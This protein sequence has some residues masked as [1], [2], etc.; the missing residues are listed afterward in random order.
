MH[1]VHSYPHLNII[2]NEVA[3]PAP[4]SEGEALHGRVEGRHPCLQLGLRCLLGGLQL[5]DL[6]QSLGE[7]ESRMGKG[8]REEMDG[9]KIRGKLEWPDEL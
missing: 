9:W 6:G 8:R 4:L 2:L 7:G 5:R 3:L 1:V